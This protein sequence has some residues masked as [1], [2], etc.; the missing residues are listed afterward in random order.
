VDASEERSGVAG[1]RKNDL[2]GEPGNGGRT[3]AH[4]ARRKISR[5]NFRV[6]QQA[7]A[8]GVVS[9]AVC[10]DQHAYV[11][12]SDPRFHLYLA[13]HFRSEPLVPQRID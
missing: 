5:D 10:I 1:G 6:W 13:K 12:D 3:F 11:L 9:I 8:E 4:V 2:V 7:V